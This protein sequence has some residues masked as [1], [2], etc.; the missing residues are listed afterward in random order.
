MYEKAQI[1]DMRPPTPEEESLDDVGQTKWKP[2]V[3][4]HAWMG[5]FWK[6][7]NAHFKKTA[8]VYIKM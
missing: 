8:K 1:P 5:E 3:R 4:G 7:L 2:G 6:K